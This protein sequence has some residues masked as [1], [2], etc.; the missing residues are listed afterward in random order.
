MTP[1]DEAGDGDGAGS[2]ISLQAEAGHGGFRLD[3]SR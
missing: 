3:A 2:R 1:D